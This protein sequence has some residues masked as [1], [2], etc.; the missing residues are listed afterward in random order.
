MVFFIGWSRIILEGIERRWLSLAFV[1]VKENESLENAIKRFRRKVQREAIMRDFKKNSV[2]LKP[3]DKRR[4]KE[5]RARKRIRKY[6]RRK[7]GR[8]NL[9]F[10]NKENI[11]IF[12]FLRAWGGKLG[13]LEAILIEPCLRS[14]IPDFYGKCRCRRGRKK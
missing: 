12:I 1:I 4:I 9:W 6:L 14:T 2:Y 5:A 11:W 8:K 10:L 7:Q 13:I 3:S